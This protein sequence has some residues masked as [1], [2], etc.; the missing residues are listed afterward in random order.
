MRVA[1]G[2]VRR[3]TSPTRGRKCALI[4]QIDHKCP[5]VAI[6]TAYKIFVIYAILFPKQR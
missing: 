2:Q 4:F 5:W 1:Y 6:K 3:K